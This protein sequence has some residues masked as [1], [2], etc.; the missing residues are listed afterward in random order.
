MSN[1][2]LHKRSSTAA[3]VPTAA[4]VTVGEL[5]LNVADGKIYLKRTDGVIVTFEPG[6][7][8]S[9]GDASPMWK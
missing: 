6:Y 9:Q 8:P 4:Q 2:I 7:V 5:V 3:A 1:T